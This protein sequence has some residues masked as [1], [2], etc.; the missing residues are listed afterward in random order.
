MLKEIKPK[1]EWRGIPVIILTALA[2]ERDKLTA[3]TIEVDD[4]L[5]KLFSTMELETIIIKKLLSGVPSIEQLATV[6]HLSVRHF[7]RKIKEITGLSPA[8]FIK[9]VQ[10]QN[11]RKELENG[12][13]I[14][15][16]E[17]AYNNGF[18]L[19]GTFSKAFKDRFG[20][21]PSEYLLHT[22]KI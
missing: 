8:L 10:L 12:V 14:S 19:P 3:L 1:N 4:Y 9:E 17:A 20:K 16:K 6:S 11:A 2:S 21:S 7:R 18:K 13:V 22:N 15:V 5:T